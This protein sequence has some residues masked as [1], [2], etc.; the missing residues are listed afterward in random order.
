MRKEEPDSESASAWQG[1]QQHKLKRKVQFASIDW[2]LAA[3]V[4][5][6]VIC[7]WYVRRGSLSMQIQGEFA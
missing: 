1:K 3:L 2:Q 5:Y 7:V 4:L 6:P